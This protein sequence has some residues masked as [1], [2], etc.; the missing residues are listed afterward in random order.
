MV[1]QKTNYIANTPPGEEYIVGSVFRVTNIDPVV[2]NPEMPNQL[3]SSSTASSSANASSVESSEE[4]KMECD[5]LNYLGGWLAK[6]FNR[7]YP[8]LGQYT[9]I[10][11][12]EHDYCLPTWVKHVSV[13]VF[14]LTTSGIFAF[15]LARQPQS[16]LDRFPPLKPCANAFFSSLVVFQGRVKVTPMY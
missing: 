1:E 12:H 15:F 13:I 11:Q 14:T 9:Y 2:N 6:K 5:G 16:V 3:T 8:Y 7:Q 10:L 4:E